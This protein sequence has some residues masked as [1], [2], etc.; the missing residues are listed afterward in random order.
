MIERKS[1][2]R[3]LVAVGAVI[4]SSGPIPVFGNPMD[5]PPIEP[6][7]EFTEPPLVVIPDPEDCV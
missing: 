1:S 7:P 5:V 6:N 4:S 3:F 2:M